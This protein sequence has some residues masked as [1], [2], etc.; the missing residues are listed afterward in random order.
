[1]AEKLGVSEYDQHPESTSLVDAYLQPWEKFATKQR[2]LEAWT[3]AH[4]LAKFTRTIN[5]YRVV[6]LT[7]PNLVIE[8]QASISGWFLEFLNHPTERFIA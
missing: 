6:K 5:W 4:H 2:L 3:L 7:V 8:H 1:M